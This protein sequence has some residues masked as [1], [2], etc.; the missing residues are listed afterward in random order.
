[1]IDNDNDNTNDRYLV[2]VFNLSRVRSPMSR[3]LHPADYLYAR[4]FMRCAISR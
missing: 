3:Q 1:M 2:P 4:C